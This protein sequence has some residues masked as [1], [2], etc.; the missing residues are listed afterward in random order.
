MRWWSAVALAEEAVGRRGGQRTA[1]GEARTRARAAV[2]EIAMPSRARLAPVEARAATTRRTTRLRMAARART[3]ARGRD[4]DGAIRTTEQ[5]VQDDARSV[6]GPRGP[7]P[8]TALRRTRKVASHGTPS[9][10]RL[11]GRGA[12]RSGGAM[13]AH[14]GPGRSA[15]SIRGVAESPGLRESAATAGTA[16][17]QTAP[18]VER[19]GRWLPARASAGR[20]VARRIGDGD[21]P[22]RAVGGG[23][24][25]RR[26]SASNVRDG[27]APRRRLAPSA[28]VTQVSRADLGNPDGGWEALVRRERLELARQ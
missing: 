4:R 19:R 16:A 13:G 14:T 9:E 23:S 5:Q 11:A 7:Q 25:D 22:V 2:E 8:A 26:V 12:G 24:G 6:S 3:E 17:G 18:E 28:I 20:R 10:G 21:H 27:V 15:R 1:E